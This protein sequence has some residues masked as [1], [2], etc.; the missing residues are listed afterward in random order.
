MEFV[1]VDITNESHDFSNEIPLS[2]QSTT[3]PEPIIMTEEELFSE[4]SCGYR[5]GVCCKRCVHV[6]DRY[7]SNS[8]ASDE[9]PKCSVCCVSEGI[10]YVATGASSVTGCIASMMFF[11]SRFSCQTCSPAAITGISAGSLLGL[12]L[13]SFG[14][15]GSLYCCN[16]NGSNY[17]TLCG[18]PRFAQGF[19]EN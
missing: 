18:C 5:S 3:G 19:K 9:C 17:A 14:C 15:A 4:N 2:F 16:K 13:I 6:H 8:E 12:G 1:T 10:G 7:I 11:C